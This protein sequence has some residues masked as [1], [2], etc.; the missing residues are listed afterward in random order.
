MEIAIQLIDSKCVVGLQGR[1][2]A[3]TAP[4]LELSLGQVIENE[5]LHIVLNLTDLEYISSAGLRIF[6]VAAKKLTIL[7]G[8]LCLA[9]LRGNIKEV[10]EISG[11]PSIMSCYDT[12]EDM[13]N[14]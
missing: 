8:T 6:L 3:V 13:P 1:L 5:N 12:L 14:S 7:K 9:G 2:D 4:E 10:I 11:F